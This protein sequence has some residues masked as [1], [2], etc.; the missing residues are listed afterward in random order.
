[1]IVVRL[2]T[3][4]AR[5]FPPAETAV[6]T[7]GSIQA[8]TKSN[9]IPDNAVL[10]LN[11]RTY[12][13]QARNL[14]L[15]GIRRISVAEC[16]ASGCPNDPE[17]ELYE[18]FSVT[19]NDPTV[20]DR[21]A[22]VFADYFGDRAHTMGQQTASEDFSGIPTA[23]GVPYTYWGL[24]GIDADTYHRA[25]AAGRISQDI[26]VNHSAEFAPALQPTLDAGTQAL[27]VAALSWLAR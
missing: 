21:V 7:V 27:I 19:E 3:I 15:D 8:G 23:L 11:L 14:I 13:E 24:G 22:G 1:M 16:R 26:P 5:E 10:Q 20:T 9:V 6:L 18:R 2:Q 25:E 12:S 17:F 4:V